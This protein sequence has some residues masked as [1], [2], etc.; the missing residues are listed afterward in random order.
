MAESVSQSH[1]DG[2]VETVKGDAW[3]GSVRAVCAICTADVGANAVF[4]VKNNSRAFPKKFIKEKLKDAPGGTSI[5]LKAVDP[6]TKV[7]LVAIGY[8]Y[9]ASKILHFIA[10][11]GAGSSTPGTPYTQ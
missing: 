6:D 9:N 7:E 3:F 11:A 5:V 8:K 2:V 1:V 10:N 4:Q